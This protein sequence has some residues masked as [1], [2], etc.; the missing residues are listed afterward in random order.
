MRTSSSRC[1]L[2]R[3]THLMSKKI[4]KAKRMKFTTDVKNAPYPKTVAPAFV[5]A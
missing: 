5:N 3:I 1:F 4:T 2:A